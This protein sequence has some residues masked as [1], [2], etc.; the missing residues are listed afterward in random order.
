MNAFEKLKKIY[1]DYDT[2]IETKNGY[3][4]LTIKNPRVL[5]KKKKCVIL[6]P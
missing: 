3:D 2:S 1:K 6:T 5:T 4:I